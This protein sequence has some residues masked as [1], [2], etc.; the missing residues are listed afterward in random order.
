MVVL[1]RRGRTFCTITYP[2]AINSFVKNSV[3]A[4][5]GFA[6]RT[7]TEETLNWI[8]ENADY[9]YGDGTT[10]VATTA[11]P[12]PS[13]QPIT[14][15]PAGWSNQLHPARQWLA[16]DARLGRRSETCPGCLPHAGSLAERRET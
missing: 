11:P 6:Y 5:Q 14:P 10:V 3:C 15:R 2:S 16:P 7:D 8:L 1:L 9:T 4:G 12:E 13:P